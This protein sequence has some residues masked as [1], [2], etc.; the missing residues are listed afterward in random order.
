MAVAAPAIR[1][2]SLLRRADNDNKSLATLTLESEI[3]FRRPAERAEFTNEL[4]GE[5]ARLAAKYHADQAEG[6][7]QFRIF[8]GGFPWIE[9]EESWPS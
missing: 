5:I 9:L 4:A 7:R 8:I 2:L 3:R 1:D 6:G